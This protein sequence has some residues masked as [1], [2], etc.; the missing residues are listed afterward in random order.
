MIALIILF[1]VLTLLAG[2]VIVVNP[3]S[4]FGLLKQ[5]VGSLALHVL[6]VG[7]RVLIG[8]LLILEA[9]SSRFPLVIEVI[10]WL[11]IIA[12]VVFALIGR[13]RFQ[14]LMRWAL[15]LAKPYGRIGG[16]IAIGFGA[17]IVYAFV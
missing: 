1:G 8:I 6:A 14:R 4:V 3:D 11:S 7:V 16:I 10:G 15:S 17:F 5:H 2:M 9:E 13:C 12:A